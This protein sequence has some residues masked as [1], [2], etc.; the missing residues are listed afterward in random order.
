MNNLLALKTIAAVLAT[1]IAG[2]TVLTSCGNDDSSKTESK[3]SS[4]SE[5]TIT[6]SLES[7][8]TTDSSTSTDESLTDS[9]EDS[10]SS[11]ANENSEEY[12]T[13]KNLYEKIKNCKVDCLAS[14]VCDIRQMSY[15]ENE[16]NIKLDDYDKETQ[17]VLI[18]KGYLSNLTDLV[19]HE[20]IDK[21]GNVIPMN[22]TTGI[23][24]YY[25]NFDS[26][27]YTYI[28]QEV[29]AVGE[30]KAEDLKMRFEV[31]GYED[32]FYVDVPLN[33][34][35]FNDYE[36]LGFK[37]ELASVTPAPG[38]FVRNTHIVIY[39]GKHYLAIVDDD[40]TSDKTIDDYN[41]KGRARVKSFRLSFYPL[42]GGMKDKSIVDA[43]DQPV[44]EGDGKWTATVTNKLD[45]FD[46][47]TH[48]SITFEVACLLGP[49]EAAPEVAD[50]IRDD[51]YLEFPDGNGGTSRLNLL[52]YN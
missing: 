39:N 38:K 37:D 15:V 25:D 14:S 12:E 2:C 36:D 20:L 34:T 33:V 7:D 35:G 31:V 16:Y 10:T 17:L 51:Y 30:Y 42:E 8:S 4:V 50:F 48:R 27:D 52:S 24:G 26:S 40:N 29:E 46:S 3:K 1:A 13:A 6:S 22:D 47:D 32:E 23:I 21:D 9:T 49:D 44:I 5:S 28:L 19:N 43:I 18:F 41:G 45:A 11:T